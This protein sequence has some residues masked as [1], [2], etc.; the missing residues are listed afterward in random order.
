MKRKPLFWVIL[1]ALLCGALVCMAFADG[2]QRSGGAVNVTDGVLQTE[3]GSL[4][5]KLYTPLTATEA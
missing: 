5:Y 2:L 4:T 3:S 1:L